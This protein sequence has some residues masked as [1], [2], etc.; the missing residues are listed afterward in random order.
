MQARIVNRKILLPAF[1]AVLAL[2][3]TFTAQSKRLAE[4]ATY[5][6]SANECVS[7][8]TVQADCDAS[9]PGAQCTI[10]G[11]SG[12]PAAWEENSDCTVALK[13]ENP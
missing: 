3:G 11:V 13:R 6:N 12:A 7:G 8:T 9:N 2:G 1:A 4:P 5:I 10:A